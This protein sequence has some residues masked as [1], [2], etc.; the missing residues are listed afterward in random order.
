MI[1]LQKITKKE[2]ISIKTKNYKNKMI[3]MAS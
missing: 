1:Y 2:A 3:K